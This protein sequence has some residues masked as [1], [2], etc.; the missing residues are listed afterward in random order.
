[1]EEFVENTAE[2]EEDSIKKR[3][4][5]IAERKKEILQVL[6]IVKCIQWDKR[7]KELEDRKAR[8]EKAKLVISAVNK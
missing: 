8:K 7:K 2:A 1:M 6:I 5:K 4:E 3:K